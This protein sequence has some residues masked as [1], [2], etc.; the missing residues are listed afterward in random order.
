MMNDLKAIVLG[1]VYNHPY[2][3]SI[4]KF[5]IRDWVVNTKKFKCNTLQLNKVIK[6]VEEELGVSFPEGSPEEF[7]KMNDFLNMPM[8]SRLIH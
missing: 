5:L 8:P 1:Y 7:I 4:T 2:S 3:D 6:E